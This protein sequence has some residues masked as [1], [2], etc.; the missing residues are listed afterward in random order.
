MEQELAP[1]LFQIL[2][3]MTQ[4]L[5]NRRF[6][7][8]G[9]RERPVAQILV[10]PSFGNYQAWDV[11][12]E[13]KRSYAPLEYHAYQTTWRCDVDREAFETPV[14]RLKYPR[15]F[16]PTVEAIQAD[17][18]TDELNEHLQRLATISVPLFSPTEGMWRDGTVYELAVGGF[19]RCGR[20]RWHCEM[21]KEWEPL[22]GPFAAFHAYLKGAIT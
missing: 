18:K 22:K 21:P 12:E 13:H 5:R 19:F 3:Q 1:E 7:P 15:P 11:L 14:A 2:H 9:T 4:D 16:V 10:L 17:L 20:V 8:E 6:L